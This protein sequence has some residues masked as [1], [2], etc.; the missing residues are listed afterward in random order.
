MATARQPA[1]ALLFCGLLWSDER[2]KEEALT[3]LAERF[4]E[5]AIATPKEE[6]SHTHYYEE[7]M[8]SPLWRSYLFFAHLFD[9]GELAALKTWT[10]RLEEDLKTRF[11]PQGR[12]VNLDPGYLTLDKLVLATT[13]DRSHRIY[14]ADGIYAESTLHFHRG[15]YRPWPWTYP[16]YAR[17]VLAPVMLAARNLLKALA[18]ETGG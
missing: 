9:P 14:I 16:D 13:K 11:R 5:P 17:P 3:I 15:A 8:G 4:G 6:F 2:A 1:K 7:E 18:R 10:N 12:P